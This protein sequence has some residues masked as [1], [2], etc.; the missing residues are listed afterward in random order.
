MANQRMR[1]SGVFLVPTRALAV[2]VIL[3][4]S[5]TVGSAQLF[6]GLRSNL[7]VEAHR[8]G[9]AYAERGDFAQAVAMFN[10]ALQ[11]DPALA[12]AYRDRGLIRA[13]GGTGISMPRLPITIAHSP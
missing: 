4:G 10:Q 11:Y 7:A 5:T 1:P 13:N 3:C 12:A 2:V 8:R 6:Q 9:V